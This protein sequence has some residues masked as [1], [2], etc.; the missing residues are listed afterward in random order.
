MFLMGS[1]RRGPTRVKE[2]LDAGVNVAVASDN[3][4]DPFRPF[5]NANLLEEALLT[6]Q[7]HKLALPDQLK[8]VFDMI[9]YNGA[10][11]SLLDNY[12]TH[13]G[14]IADLVLL[15]AA[16]EHE[17]LVSQARKL[18]VIKHGKVIYGEPKNA[19]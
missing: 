3:I 2:F 10:K 4:R 16:T 19:E 17:A 6:A 12:G 18:L 15:D 8:K 14:A 7:V 5:G 9:T 13:T 1:G 11:N